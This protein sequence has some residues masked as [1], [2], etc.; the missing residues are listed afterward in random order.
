MNAACHNVVAQM[1]ATI[2]PRKAV[3]EFGSRNVNGDVRDLFKRA[4]VHEGVDVVEGPGVDVVEDAATYTPDFECDTVVC[5]NMLEHAPN[6]EAILANACRILQPGGWLVFSAGGPDWPVHGANG[7]DLLAG[8]FYQPITEALLRKWTAGLERVQV[9]EFEKLIYLL[10]RK[11]GAE[12][13]PTEAELVLTQGQR[14]NVGCGAFPLLYWVNL[15]ANPKVPADIHADATEY[16]L[17][18]EPGTLAEVYAGHFLEH[19]TLVGASAFLDAVWHA[20]KPGGK[21]GIV[22]PDM[23]EVL[24]RWMA[25]SIDAV[26]WPA[27]TWWPVANF[28]AVCHLFLYSDVQES[29]H[30][31]AYTEH[32]LAR[33]LAKAGFGGFVK[34]DRYRDPRLGSGAWYQMGFDCYKPEEAV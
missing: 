26:E 27:G 18:V 30:R 29:P 15:D 28:E 7:G 9:R 5:L 25:D 6:A 32:T 13:E 8:E 19:L 34:I 1:L 14:L 21:L 33:L 23:G 16:L 20:L 22:V 11:P 12:A 17:G 2:P 4:G 24:S 3:V 31:W 10:G